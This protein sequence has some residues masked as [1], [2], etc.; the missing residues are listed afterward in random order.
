LKKNTGVIERP[1]FRPQQ[2]TQTQT[3]T[4]DFAPQQK[5]V[6]DSNCSFE[7]IKDRWKEITESIANARLGEFLK[8]ATPMRLAGDTLAL[9]F[10]AADEFMMKLCQSNGKSEAIIQSLTEAIGKNLKISF[11]LINSPTQHT[12]KPK[13]KG[14]R[15]GQKVIDDAANNPF[16]KNILSELDGNIIDVEEQQ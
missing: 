6:L 11:E 16:I 14:A 15:A 12:P 10:G 5:Q 9:G 13:P 7:Q 3:P 2:Q 1:A 4:Q 8:K